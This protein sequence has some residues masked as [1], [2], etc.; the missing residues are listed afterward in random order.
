MSSSAA[1]DVNSKTP[2]SPRVVTETKTVV[3]QLV[4][5]RLMSS[6]SIDVASRMHRLMKTGVYPSSELLVP[7]TRNEIYPQVYNKKKKKKRTPQR[8][9]RKYSIFVPQMNKRKRLGEKDENDPIEAYLRDSAAAEAKIAKAAAAAKKESEDSQSDTAMETTTAP[10]E[11]TSNP[12]PTKPVSSS[13]TAARPPTTKTQAQQLDIWGKRPP[14]EPKQLVECLICGR[15]V[16][17]LRFAP[18]LDKCM[19][20]GTT[21]RAAALAASGFV[22]QQLSSGSNSNTSAAAAASR[23]SSNGGSSKP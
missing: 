22:P 9:E 2:S 18:H 13:S 14:K 16:N 11:A 3:A 5:E 21:V 4:Y 6:I 23:A 17:T 19:G 20:I 10:D 1:K 8:E 15:Q 7:K 12:P